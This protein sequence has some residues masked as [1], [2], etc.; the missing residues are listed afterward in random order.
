MILACVYCM[1]FTLSEKHN[2]ILKPGEKMLDSHDEVEETEDGQKIRFHYEV[3]N[4]DL[5]E[6]ARSDIPVAVIH[7]SLS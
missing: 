6:S 4:S 1:V 5:M 2:T 7:T 3:V